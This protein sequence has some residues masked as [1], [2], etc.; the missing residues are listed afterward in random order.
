MNLV[1]YSD[2]YW[3]RN[4]DNRRSTSGFCFK[5]SDNSGVLSWSSRFQRCVSTSTAEAE[6]NAVVET[7]RKE[8]TYRAYLAT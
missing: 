1:S 5:L 7:V 2:A 4:I 8:F 6:Q 3:A